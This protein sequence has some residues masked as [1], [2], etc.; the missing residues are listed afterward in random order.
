[1]ISEE[2]QK[3]DE[4]FEQMLLLI[5]DNDQ[6]F[7][8]KSFISALLRTVDF[9][10]VKHVDRFFMLFRAEPNHS[11]EAL[12]ELGLIYERRG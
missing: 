1:M 4:P 11:L 6:H 8:D 7:K 5:L 12:Y 2:Q 3:K 9:D 10:T